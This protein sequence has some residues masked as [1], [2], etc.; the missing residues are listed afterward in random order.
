MQEF[1]DSFCERCGTRYTFRSAPP[2]GPALAGARL[3]A[4]GLKNFVMTDGSSLDEAMHAARIDTDHNDTVRAVE[5]FHQTFNFCMTCRQYACDKCWNENQGACLSCAPLWDRPAVAPQ[6]HLIIRTPVSRLGQSD[7]EAGLDPRADGWNGPAGDR[8]RARA[9]WPE[10]D[11]A[12]SR[13]S[14]S[15]EEGTTPTR[16]HRPKPESR[17][18]EQDLARSSGLGWGPEAAFEPTVIPEQPSQ[19]GPPGQG[20]SQPQ[21]LRTPSWVTQREQAATEELQ[22]RS[23]SWKDNDDG[24]SLWPAGETPAAKDPVREFADWLPASPEPAFGRA[25]EPNGTAA[26]FERADAAEPDAAEQQDRSEPAAPPAGE[27]GAEPSPDEADVLPEMALTPE[28]LRLIQARLAKAR[29][30]PAARAAESTPET[31]TPPVQEPFAGSTEAQADVRLRYV[32][33][34]EQDGGV[35]ATFEKN[36]RDEDAAEKATGAEPQSAR[37]SSFDRAGAMREPAD[38]APATSEESRRQAIVGRL[39]GRRHQAEPP[40]PARSSSG[41]TAGSSVTAPTRPGQSGDPP[42]GNWPRP[43]RWLDRPIEPHD[44]WADEDASMHQTGPGDRAPEP[45]VAGMEPAVE[46][47]VRE[48]VAAAEAAAEAETSAESEP[49]PG[50]QEA[51]AE[52]ELPAEAA[53]GV[54]LPAEAG[55]P[56]DLRTATAVPA[57][58]SEP[59]AEAGPFALPPATADPWSTSRPDTPARAPAEWPTT[60]LPDWAVAAKLRSGKL[61]PE[62]EPE[63]SAQRAA[64]P[65]MGATWP[66]TDRQSSPWQMPADAA[67]TPPALAA[68]KADAEDTTESPL[69]AALWEESSH[70]VLDHGNVRVCHRC[71]LPVSTHARFCRRCGTKQE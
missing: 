22:S 69:V 57:A 32:P 12:G 9:E 31:A 26:A 25:D 48:T 15:G 2:K 46:P 17:S 54:E 47:S 7:A 66:A 14:Q 39:L 71:A 30:S 23:Q 43:T 44:W 34:P 21:E 18:P 38:E 68:R 41:R 62:P 5:Q 35:P 58:E 55:P 33:A 52:V 53:A 63:T 45:N 70:P 49:T 6:D 37:G 10:T 4:R 19:T 1:A 24:W 59:A 8:S 11:M 27:S 65:P 50:I 42:T 40:H 67:P 28:E 20:P 3:L 61:G 16:A 29:R 13:D 64:W 60:D 36:A 51:A 56:T